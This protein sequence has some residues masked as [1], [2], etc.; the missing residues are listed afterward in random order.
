MKLKTVLFYITDVTH[1]NFF[2]DKIRVFLKN[3]CFNLSKSVL[4]VFLLPQIIANRNT[5]DTDTTDFYRLNVSKKINIFLVRNVSYKM[6]DV[7]I[8][9]IKSN[10]TNGVQIG[11]LNK[12]KNLKGLQ[13]GLWNKNQHRSLPFI[14]WGTKKR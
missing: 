1:C 5:D 13:I 14:N 12:A 2:L 10:V 6:N 7:S 8:G 9:I 4:S 3:P 11:V